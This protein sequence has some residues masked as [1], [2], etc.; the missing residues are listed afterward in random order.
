VLTFRL[1]NKKPGALFTQMGVLQNS[2]ALLKIIGDTLRNT[3]HG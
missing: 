2:V 1:R 3:E